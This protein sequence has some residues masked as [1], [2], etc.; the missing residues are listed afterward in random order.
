MKNQIILLFST[1]TLMTSCSE[2]TEHSVIE[3]NS[4]I[5]LRKSSHEEASVAVYAIMTGHGGAEPCREYGSCHPKDEPG[6]IVLDNNQSESDLIER[7]LT[8]DECLVKFTK[9]SGDSF[10]V[11]LIESPEFFERDLASRK[12]ERG[13]FSIGQ[14]GVFVEVMEYF[15]MDNPNGLKAG[16]YKLLD[17]RDSYWSGHFVVTAK[18]VFEPNIDG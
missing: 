2:I 14:P 13:L 11:D 9:L 8:Q 5:E 7:A 16:K 15:R 10:R 17:T 4:E 6:L 1:L 18:D 12:V 3:S